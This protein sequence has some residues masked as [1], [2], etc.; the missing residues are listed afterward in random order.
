MSE[1]DSWLHKTV[2]EVSLLVRDPHSSPVKAAEEMVR[3][4]CTKELRGVQGGVSGVE[5][6]IANAGLDLVIMAVWNVAASQMGAENLPV[7]GGG[8]LE[9]MPDTYFREGYADVADVL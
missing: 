9:L 5:E 4:F 6:Y 2:Y 8:E 1:G 3:Q 7:S